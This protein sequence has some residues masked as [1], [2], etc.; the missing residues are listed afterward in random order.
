MFDF[1]EKATKALTDTHPD[2]KAF[3]SVNHSG[4][5][6]REYFAVQAMSGLLAHYGTGIKDMPQDSIEHWAVLHADMLIEQLNKDNN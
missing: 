6:T 4:L 2:S 5:T 3:G 1:I